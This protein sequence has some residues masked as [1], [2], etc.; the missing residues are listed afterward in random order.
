MFVPHHTGTNSPDPIAL[1]RTQ[2]SDCY[3]SLTAFGCCM[4]SFSTR[5]P[6]TVY[7]DTIVSSYIPPTPCDRV[8]CAQ[9]SSNGASPSLTFFFTPCPPFRR[10][11]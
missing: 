1:L 6:R 2:T 7:I 9:R 8:R 5:V 10:Q 3:S 4:S 11:S